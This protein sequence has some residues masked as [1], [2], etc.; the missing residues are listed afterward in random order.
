[1]DPIS[2][3]D[4]LAAMLRQRLLERSKAGK[5][6]RSGARPA[7][8]AGAARRGEAIAALAATD[9]LDDRQ[10]G[11]AII[12]DILADQLGPQLVNEASFQQ[13]VD[14]VAE[15]LRSDS[16]TAGLF[17][18]AIAEVRGSARARPRS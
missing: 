15:T 18:K 3:A 7:T 11:R 6:A 9:Q 1:M 14:R 5:A 8:G 17:E 16:A 13:V 4:R 10:L 12:E 2:T